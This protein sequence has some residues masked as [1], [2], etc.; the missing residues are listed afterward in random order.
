MHH[1]L[2]NAAVHYDMQVMDRFI[3]DYYIYIYSL[4]ELLHGL[5]K[6]FGKPLNIFVL[7]VHTKTNL[8]YFIFTQSFKMVFCCFIL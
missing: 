3:M 1:S 5:H 4:V 7:L 2:G 6:G 8:Y